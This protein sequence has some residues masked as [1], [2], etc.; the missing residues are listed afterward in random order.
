MLITGIITTYLVLRLVVGRGFINISTHHR[1]K[2][3]GIPI[4]V[5]SAMDVVCKEALES[6]QRL[7]TLRIQSRACTLY[8]LLLRSCS[9]LT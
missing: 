2:F 9:Q 1:A 3:W 5:V 7:H 8:I 4:Q 6:S